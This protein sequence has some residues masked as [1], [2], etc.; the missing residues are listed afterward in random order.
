MDEAETWNRV[1]AIL[2]TASRNCVGAGLIP[3]SAEE[4]WLRHQQ[5]V[6]KPPLKA[7]TGWCWSRRLILRDILLM[8][9]PPILRQGGEYALP[10]A[11]PWLTSMHPSAVLLP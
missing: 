3:S 4:G 1:R 5:N 2:G 9:P 10:N 6:A 7:Q 8:A 11:Y